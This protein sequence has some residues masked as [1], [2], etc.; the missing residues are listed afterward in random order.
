MLVTRIKS[1]LI[2]ITIFTT[3]VYS[4]SS[5]TLTQCYDHP[6][7]LNRTHQIPI[8]CPIIKQSIDEHLLT[9]QNTTNMFVVNFT[10]GTD[11]TILC[12]KVKNAF[13]TAGKIISSTLT[14]NV[15]IN[16]NASFVDFCTTM[17]DCG[18]TG[19]ITLGGASPA[20]SIL[21]QDD[22]GLTR[23]YP[24]ALVKQFQFQRHPEFSEFDIKAL[25]NS[26]VTNF[27]FDGDPPITSSQ[28]DFLYVI[29]HEYIHGLGLY[30]SFDDHFNN[31]VPTI[32][33]PKIYMSE[34]SIDSSLTF[35]GF[36]EA[37]FDKYMIYLPTGGRISSIITSQLNQ[38]AGGV[39]TVFLDMNEFS[40]KF[41]SS[42][43]YVLSLNMMTCAITPYSLGFLPRGANKSSEA[44]I[45]ETSL[46]PYRRG[47]SIMH[48]N[49]KTYSK[50]S[51][52]L[53][54]YSADRGVSLTNLVAA[55][56][57][58]G[59]PIGPKLKLFLETLGYQSSENPN[60]YRPSVDITSNSYNKDNKDDTPVLPDGVNMSSSA[61]L[62]VGKTMFSTMISVFIMIQQFVEL[63]RLRS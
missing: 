27:W 16:V 29:L 28:Q 2:I 57:N 41:K 59:S 44:I 43:Q 37:A 55:S 32:M 12:T 42:S 49:Y 47:S 22:D 13:E 56:G 40:S 34:N 1:S 6:D 52:F 36:V 25:F 19:T 33:T 35:N 4:L 18:N 3:L 62:G 10:C 51:D 63:S 21:L 23:L 50:T 53:M 45:L 24:Q 7:P 11:S 14:L 48:F 46:K 58:S 17:G 54:K 9:S 38:F 60:P 8:K 5:N 15:P 39:G 20:R 61:Q 31:S 30:S 26:A